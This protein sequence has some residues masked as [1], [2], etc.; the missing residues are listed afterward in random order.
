MERFCKLLRK[1]ATHNCC[2]V[3]LEELTLAVGR[4]MQQYEKPNPT[5]QILC[6]KK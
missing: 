5:L 6:D 2:F 3:T 4:K 1:P